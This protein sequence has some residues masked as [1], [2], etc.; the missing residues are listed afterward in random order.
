ML[1]NLLYRKNRFAK[2]FM[3]NIKFRKRNGSHYNIQMH[4]ELS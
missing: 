3:E 1:Y 2:I 4:K